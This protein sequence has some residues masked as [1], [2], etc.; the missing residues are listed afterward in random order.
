MSSTCFSPHLKHAYGRDPQLTSTSWGNESPKY[1]GWEC[2]GGNLGAHESEGLIE[3][4]HWTR[5]YNSPRLF[6]HTKDK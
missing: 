2:K 3:G 4:T 6:D 1:G 5:I